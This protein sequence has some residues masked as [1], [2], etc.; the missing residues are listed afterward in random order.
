[1]SHNI[2]QEIYKIYPLTNNESEDKQ[3]LKVLSTEDIRQLTSLDLVMNAVKEAYIQKA[4]NDGEDWPLIFHEFKNKTSDMDIKSGVLEKTNTFGLK[5]VSLHQDNIA[6]QLPLLMSTSLVFDT[7]TGQPKGLLNFEDLTGIRTAAAATLGALTLA[8]PNSKTCLLVGCGHLAPFIVYAMNEAFPNLEKII[9][10][11]PLDTNRAIL[12]VEKFKDLIPKLEISSDIEKAIKQSNIIVTATPTK[13]AIIK[14]DWINEGTHIS[15]LGADM[16]DK[17]EI[18]ANITTK[19]K[20][21]VDDFNQ[22][23][24]VGEFE[25][26]YKNHLIDKGDLTLIGDAIIDNTKGRTNPQEITIFDSTGISLQD[27]MVAD[28]LIEEA[29]KKNIGIDIK[30]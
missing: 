26:A 11:D 19:A 17:N 5:V 24:N 20:L 30:F 22:S 15:C 4:N 8:N 1:M 25:V 16:S 9:I 14:S 27:I 21:F 13:E 3:L 7:V 10:V 28:A 2:L 23:V 29:K 18:E 6:K 12:F